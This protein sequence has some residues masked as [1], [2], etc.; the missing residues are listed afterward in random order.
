MSSFL[1]TYKQNFLLTVC[2][3]LWTQPKI[4]GKKNSSLSKIELSAKI[5][6]GRYLSIK[7][8]AT[9]TFIGLN[10]VFEYTI[11]Q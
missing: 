5:L 1:E 7:A 2:N 3:N 8:F 11:I 9:G 6:G 4:R 10:M